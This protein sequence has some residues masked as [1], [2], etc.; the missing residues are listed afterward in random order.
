MS[1]E[2]VGGGGRRWFKVCREIELKPGQG[3]SVSLL[4]R[5]YAVFNV[6][7]SLYGMDGACRHM[8]ANLAAGRLDGNVLECFMHGWRYDV[9]TGECLTREYGRVSTYPVKLDSGNVL[10]GIEWPPGGTPDE[11]SGSN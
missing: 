2:S 1:I 11:S 9:T 5:P 10:I 4:G 3:K 8:K 7:G 6:E